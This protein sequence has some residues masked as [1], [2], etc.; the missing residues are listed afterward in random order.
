VLPALAVISL[1]MALTVAPLTATVISAVDV[2]YAGA[3]SGVNNAVA[4]LAALLA[5]AL[6]GPVLMRAGDPIAFVRAFHVAAGISAAVVAAGAA[7]CAA[8]LKARS[9]AA[10]RRSGRVE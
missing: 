1:G 2:A 7:I 3:A 8:M 10:V 5:S 6:V 4:R 9:G